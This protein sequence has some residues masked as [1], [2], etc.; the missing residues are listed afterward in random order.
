MADYTFSGII[1]DPTETSRIS[2]AEVRL[3]D[4]VT[5]DVLSTTTSDSVGAWSIDSGTGFTSPWNYFVVAI[6]DK[7]LGNVI[8][9]SKTFLKQKFNIIPDFVDTDTDILKI[10]VLRGTDNVIRKVHLQANSSATSDGTIEIR[11]AASGAGDAITIDI[12]SGDSDITSTATL[13]SSD[14]IYVRS[15]T[16]CGIGSLDI[17]FTIEEPLLVYPL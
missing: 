1:Y 6:E 17:E 9:L 15:G 5:N 10:P 13:T 4:K 11:N 12:T 7:F 16:P 8:N 14:F 2:G 3:Y